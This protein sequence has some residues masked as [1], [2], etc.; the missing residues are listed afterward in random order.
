MCL[1][2]KEAHRPSAWPCHLWLLDKITNL[3]SLGKYS[4]SPL[5]NLVFL[6]YPSTSNPSL[7]LL[8]RELRLYLW[9]SR[10]MWREE[11]NYFCP[12][13]Q[14]DSQPFADPLSLTTKSDDPFC[15]GRTVEFPTQLRE[16]GHNWTSFQSHF[17][18]SFSTS[19][20]IHQRWKS[21]HRD[22]KMLSMTQ[23]WVL[24]NVLWIKY[25]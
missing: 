22:F 24:L 10:G 23:Q 16:A 6:L 3:A 1:W 18:D 11:N 5:L 2:R 19:P 20:W 14:R 25:P 13:L 15:K 21:S 17:S 8:R 9:P 12:P 4:L 7:S